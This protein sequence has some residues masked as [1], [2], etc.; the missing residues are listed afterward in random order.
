MTLLPLWYLRYF[1]PG[2]AKNSSTTLIRISVQ[3]GFSNSSLPF[4]LPSNLCCLTPHSG[5]S[6]VP[7]TP[8]GSS[9]SI[10]QQVLYQSM[11]CFSPFTI[12]LNAASR[13]C[14]ICPFF[15]TPCS[16]SPQCFRLKR[17]SHRGIPEKAS[18]TARYPRLKVS[19]KRCV[20]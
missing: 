18:S 12:F 6:S 3:N 5:S 11:S 17:S 16:H 10:S 7:L 13:A 15:L 20:K 2:P 14:S 19:E 4:P 9:H 1:L 8:L